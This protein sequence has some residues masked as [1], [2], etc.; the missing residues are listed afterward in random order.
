MLCLFERKPN[1]IV[2]SG[3]I[4]HNMPGND[5][6]SGFTACMAEEHFTYDYDSEKQTIKFFYTQKITGKQ[7][8]KEIA[9]YV[10]R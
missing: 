2:F 8:I 3:G 6:I 1:I 4:G 5:I 10:P 9:Q 7:K